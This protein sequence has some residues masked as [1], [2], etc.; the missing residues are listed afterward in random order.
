ME[1]L[2]TDFLKK[3]DTYIDAI[4]RAGVVLEERIKTTIGGGG[5]GKFKY[6]VDLVDYA[7]MADGGKLIISENPAEQDGVHRLFRGVM[8][9]VRN[10]P[11][12][13]KLQYSE[14]EVREAVRLIDYLLWLLQ[15]ATSRAE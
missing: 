15:Q 8:Q 13:K 9:Y 14:Y 10:P 4:R 5:R 2:S 6:G 1:Y 11:A 7:L 12:H 3:E